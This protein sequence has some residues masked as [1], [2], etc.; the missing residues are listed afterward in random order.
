MNYSNFDEDNQALL[1]YIE[2]SCN[3][4]RIHSS[5]T[6]LILHAFEIQEKNKMANLSLQKCV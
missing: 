6:Y 3:C 1:S 5:I 4:N 2:G